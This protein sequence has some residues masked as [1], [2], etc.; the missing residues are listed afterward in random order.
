MSK[1]VRIIIVSF[2]LFG[3]VLGQ[4]AEPILMPIP[5]KI[6][7]NNSRFEIE[8]NFTIGFDKIIT[9]RLIFNANHF[10][11]RL[12]GRTGTFFKQGLINENAKVD[13]PSLVI[14]IDREGELKPGEDES[15]KLTVLSNKILLK[16]KTDIGAIRGLETLLQLSGADKSYYFVGCEIED[17]PRFVWRGLLMDVCR[18]FMPLEVIKRN[19]RG[20]A[21][22]KMNVLHLHLS[23]DQ[24]FRVESR[25]YPLLTQMGSD[26]LYFT[27]EQI[28][29]IINYASLFGIRVVPEF[30][31]PGHATSWL[32]GYPELSSKKQE[33]SIERKWGIFDATL[34]PINEYTYNFLDTLFAE[35]T[36]LF[37][38]QYFHIGGDE[39]SGKHWDSNPEIQLFMQQNDIKDN[40][41][42]QAYF[43]NRVL[44]ILTKYDKKMVGWDEIQHDDM[45]KNIVIQSWR[46]KTGL[47]KAAKSGFQVILS[48][49]YYIDLIH[50][51]RDHYLN[52][53]LPEDIDLSDEEKKLVLGGEATMWAEFVTEETVD[54]RIW[55]RTAA[56]AERLWSKNLSNDIDDMYERLNYISFRME[57]LGLLHIKN[58][59][60]MMR[61]LTNNESNL[62]PLKTF[63]DVVEPVKNYRRGQL[64]DYTQQSPLTRVVDAAVPD[65]PDARLF[66]LLV[67]QYI[68]DGS[69]KDEVTDF[70]KIWSKNDIKLN[71][72]ISKNPILEE[73][74]ELSSDLSYISGK[75]L[76][77]LEGKKIEGE[78]S[79]SEKFENSSKPAGQVELIVLN[80]LKKL[81]AH[82]K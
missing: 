61:R 48:N 66:N 69:G 74:R 14:S 23:E 78:E 28:K 34:N 62:T 46:G 32:V 22:A 63:L 16:A 67:D 26:G 70:L 18:H 52:D 40:H 30:D 57:E 51:A 36:S 68:S 7:Y 58:Q 77:L 43:N 54:S 6:E 33:Y 59:Q 9:E 37:P 29:E 17:E 19:I 4:V 81:Y 45:P 5:E 27:Q 2:L 71:E 35:M 49:G 65:A 24:G 42:L 3:G 1:L 55:P 50:P 31:I 21:A 80:P 20:L 13:N 25:E 11:K 79:L 60:M 82:L 39:N 47:E 76:V 53:P 75:M 41:A 38:D 10:I 12:D 44:K 72:I 73:I 64:K 8:E 56:I 15:Y